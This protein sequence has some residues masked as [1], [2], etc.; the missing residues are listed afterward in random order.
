MHYGSQDYLCRLCAGYIYTP[1]SIFDILFHLN[2]KV[3]WQTLQY[4][5]LDVA[6]Q[7]FKFLHLSIILLQ[8]DDQQLIVE[9]SRRNYG[10]ADV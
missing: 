9:V 1:W 2:K 5:K 3:C 7:R 4:R 8:Q 10:P 6:S